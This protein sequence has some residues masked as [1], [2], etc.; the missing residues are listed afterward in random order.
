M[1]INW[2]KIQ[3]LSKQ[4]P[5]T[6]ATAWKVKL[7]WELEKVTFFFSHRQ[8]TIR[9][10]Y[11]GIQ[12]ILQVEQPNNFLNL[13]LIG[14]F[15]IEVM[16]LESNFQIPFPPQLWIWLRNHGM[17]FHSS[18]WARHLSNQAPCLYTRTTEAFAR[19]EHLVTPQNLGWPGE[20]EP[21][22]SI[23]LWR[24]RALLGQLK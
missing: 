1:G 11:S 9:M 16:Q 20:P 2:E 17:N 8:L 23:A 14:N 6:R 10:T 13:I 12:S 18:S 24:K 21:M 15:A 22:C 3:E 19:A 5:D 7:D 4:K